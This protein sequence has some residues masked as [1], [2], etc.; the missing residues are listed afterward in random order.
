AD[1]AG[2]RICQRPR[3][4]RRDGDGDREAPADI[5]EETAIDASAGQVA[6]RD[7]AADVAAVRHVH[8]IAGRRGAVRRSAAR[9]IVCQGDVVVGDERASVA[10]IGDGPGPGE[11]R[12]DDGAAANVVRLGDLEVRQQRDRDRYAIAAIVVRLVALGYHGARVHTTDAAG[13]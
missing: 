8:E 3:R 4:R 6:A 7:R 12:V 13:A 9:E 1:A 11:R 2:A 5:H 10:G